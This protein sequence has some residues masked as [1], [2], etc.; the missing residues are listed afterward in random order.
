MGEMWV[1]NIESENE[2]N[3]QK[4]EESERSTAD[5]GGRKCPFQTE[6]YTRMKKGKN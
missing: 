4:K 5:G 6:W 2:P 3:E 1:K